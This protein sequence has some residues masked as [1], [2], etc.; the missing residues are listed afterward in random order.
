MPSILAPSKISPSTS[1]KT[2]TTQWFE[3][4]GKQ[5]LGLLAQQ[6]KS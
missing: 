2:N 5:K 3:V 4:Q 1:Q 6:I